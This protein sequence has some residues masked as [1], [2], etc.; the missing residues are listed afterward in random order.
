[1]ALRRVT[2]FAWLQQAIQSQAP[3]AQP[4]SALWTTLPLD[5]WR[6]LT[7]ELEIPPASTRTG[8]ESFR[9]QRA[10]TR[11]LGEPRQQF[12]TRSGSRSIAST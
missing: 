2:A 1:M 9:R 6:Y 11:W 3:R 12:E 4:L 7:G 5:P 8:F 10:S